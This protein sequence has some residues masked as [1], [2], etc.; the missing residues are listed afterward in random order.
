MV[1]RP[2]GP[3]G[4]LGGVTH[5]TVFRT[6]VEAHEVIIAVL[7]RFPSR[8]SE[9]F[10]AED[11]AWSSTLGQGAIEGRRDAGGLE[12]GDGCDA[13]FG[14]DLGSDGLKVSDDVLNRAGDGVGAARGDGDLPCDGRDGVVAQGA[15]HDIVCKS[16]CLRLELVLTSCRVC[17]PIGPSQL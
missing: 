1:E 11:V 14:Q 12:A 16:R 7:D 13:G 6:A 10:I 9:K 3:G 2:G 5:R 15:L 17:W 8:V 4:G